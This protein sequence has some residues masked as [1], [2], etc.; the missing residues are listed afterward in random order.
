MICNVA[1]YSATAKHL[2]S[3]ILYCEL[4]DKR[5]LERPLAV[6]VVIDTGSSDSVHQPCNRGIY[7]TYPRLALVLEIDRTSRL[8][9]CSIGGTLPVC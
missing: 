5:A 9:R 4:R 3:M 1:A 8:R 2:A 6:W 7:D